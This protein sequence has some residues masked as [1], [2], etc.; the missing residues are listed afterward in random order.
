[1]Y[2][3]TVVWELV[4]IGVYDY[5][6][7]YECDYDYDYEYDYDWVWLWLWVWLSMSMS[8][9]MTMS[10]FECIA[11]TE[12]TLILTERASSTLFYVLES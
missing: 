4:R 9:T 8:T 2:S 12:H 10:D 3:V 7:D 6:Y 11:T 1:V 5:D